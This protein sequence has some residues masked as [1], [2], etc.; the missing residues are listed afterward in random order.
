MCFLVG[1]KYIYYNEPQHIK[2]Y[3]NMGAIYGFQ[4]GITTNAVKYKVI[5]TNVR[6]QV[7]S[8]YV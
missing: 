3:K 1:G 5:Y 6:G 8:M 7:T 2:I 4:L